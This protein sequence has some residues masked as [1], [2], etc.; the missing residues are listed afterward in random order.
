MT[1]VQVAAA[2]IQL[3]DLVLIAQ[4]PQ[5]A[6]QGGKWEFPGGKI[7][8]GESAWQALARELHEELGI[9][10]LVG[11]PL[12]TLSHDYGDK[13]VKLFFYRVTE[14]TGQA[15][16]L[17]GQEVRWVRLRELPQYEFPAANQPVLQALLQPTSPNASADV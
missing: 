1:E 3:G 2:V 11:E 9:L 12:L 6:H 13:R 17:E 14:I 8:A 10:P 5:Q 16:G 15:Q 7:E 4:R